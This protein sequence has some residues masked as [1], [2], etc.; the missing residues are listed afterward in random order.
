[1]EK[2]YRIHTLKK[3][4]TVDSVAEELGI[5]PLEVRGWH[6]VCCE[7]KNT[8]GYD[9]PKNLKELLVYANIRTFRKELYPMTTFA[10]GHTLRANPSDKKVT[11]N[12]NYNII[13]NETV[14]SLIAFKISV[15]CKQK[16]NGHFLYEIDKSEIYIN[17][18]EPNYMLDTLAHKVSQAIYPLQIIVNEE[19]KYTGVHDFST[20]EKRWKK[21]REEIQEYHQGDWVKDYLELTDKSFE[22]E[23]SF[24]FFLQSDWFLNSFFSG[25]YTNYSPFLKFENNVTFPILP[26]IKPLVFKVKQSI[27]DYLDEFNQVI[28]E[29]IGFLNDDRAKAD[30]ENGLPFSNYSL[31]NPDSEKAK[32][33]FTSKYFINSKN[34]TIES[35]FLQCSIELEQTKTV[36]IIVSIV[37]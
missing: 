10:M 5:T 8:I 33:T 17:E 15:E 9:F 13:N 24:Y 12:V 36:Q 31:S 4:D 16:S 2:Q 27:D 18:E 3:G 7:P 1:M 20:I 37:D 35:L 34:N 25:I 23:S 14:T 32:G 30:I 6:N 26:K 28:V 11:Y 29:Q 21:T 22:S 19:G